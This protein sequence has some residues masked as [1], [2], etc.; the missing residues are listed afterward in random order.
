MRIAAILLIF[1]SLTYLSFADSS[2]YV[3]SDKPTMK[4]RLRCQLNLPEET[5]KSVSYLPEQ[6]LA[7]SV[8]SSS[9][10]RDNC[11]S[12]Y[13]LYNSCLY[14]E[15]DEKRD[16]CI[17]P[18]LHLGSSTSSDVVQCNSKPGAY[19]ALCLQSLRDNTYKLAI[20]RMNVVEYKVW[21]MIKL[22]LNEDDGLNFM[23]TLEESKA[24]FNSAPSLTYKQTYLEE[25]N[26]TWLDFKESVRKQLNLPG[27]SS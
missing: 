23:V 14:L 7:L 19:K 12:D 25:L 24:K 26:T 27:E 6:C 4:E 13:K 9:S 8:T 1:L 5:L 18:K 15:N 20:F 16:A 3:C 21:K 10:G 17:K 22:G 11:I 2:T